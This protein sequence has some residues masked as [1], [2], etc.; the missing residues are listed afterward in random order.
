[1]TND[2]EILKLAERALNLVRDVL[3]LLTPAQ[4][5]EA[6]D[7]RCRLERLKR[8]EPLRTYPLFAA[9]LDLIGMLA[10]WRKRAQHP[11]GALTA[12]R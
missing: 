5:A 10:R 4:I 8:G 9:G 3:G 6:N 12:E 7:T 11:D 2:D 1:M